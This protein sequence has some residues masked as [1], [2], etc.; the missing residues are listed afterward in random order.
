M[1]SLQD[2]IIY[3]LSILDKN[4]NTAIVGQIFNTLLQYQKQ[5]TDNGWIPSIDIIEEKNFIYVYV[6]IPGV[7]P[8][9]IDMNVFNNKIEISGER[10]KCYNTTNILKKEI[11][12]GKFKREITLPISITKRESITVNN[13]NGVLNII[14]N[15]TIEEE[16]KFKINL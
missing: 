3:G 16:N 10:N 5:M 15:K 12:Y 13:L 14:I 2:L 9:S 6:D 11:N 1:S 7:I 4:P 8:G